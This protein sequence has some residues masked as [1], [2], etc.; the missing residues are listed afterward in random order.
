MA[1]AY[2]AFANGGVYVKPRIIDHILLPDGR[3]ISYKTEIDHRV[4]S[5]QSSEIITSMLHS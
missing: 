3:V 2:S 5:Q 1:A 4:I